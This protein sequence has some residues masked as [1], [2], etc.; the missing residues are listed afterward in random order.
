M[1]LESF[2]GFDRAE[3]FDRVLKNWFLGRFG[4]T[5]FRFLRDDFDQNVHV[6]LDTDC[7]WKRFRGQ[8]LHIRFDTAFGLETY[9]RT[10]F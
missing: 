1:Q 6:Q 7:N 9:S 10:S 3:L 4:L 5:G 8:S 2:S